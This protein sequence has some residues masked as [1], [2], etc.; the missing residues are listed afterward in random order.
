MRAQQQAAATRQG[1]GPGATTS[2]GSSNGRGLLLRPAPLHNQDQ[3]RHQGWA[4]RQGPGLRVLLLKQQPLL[5]RLRV[6]WQRFWRPWAGARA[7]ASS[8][9]WAAC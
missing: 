4:P 5:R 7:R 8:S 3:A 6:A 2:W 1:G 9:P